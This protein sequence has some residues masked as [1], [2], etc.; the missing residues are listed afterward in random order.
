MTLR[1]FFA[2]TIVFFTFHHLVFAHKL[3]IEEISANHFQFRYDDGTV[4]SLVTVSGYDRDNNLLFTKGVSNS[5]TVNIDSDFHRI[6]GDDGI[7]HRVSYLKQSE[8]KVGFLSNVPNWLK[9]LLG[10]S[11]LLCVASY[12]QF[13]KTT[14][15][16]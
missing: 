13:R 3:V 10:V 2:F 7:G 8:V 9:S 12:F 16:T 4:A 15:Q 14:T 1:I 6:V 11:L 5:G